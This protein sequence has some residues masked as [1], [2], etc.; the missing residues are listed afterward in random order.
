MLRSCDV[1]MMI[2]CCVCVF[3]SGG[4]LHT[5]AGRDTQLCT[6]FVQSQL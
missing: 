4:D 5:A 6:G 2:S 1:N 3:G